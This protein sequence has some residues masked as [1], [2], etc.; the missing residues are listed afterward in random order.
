M[1]RGVGWNP[2]ASAD[3]Q[4]KLGRT[5]ALLDRV[6]APDR[7][8]TCVLIAGTKGKGSTAAFLARILAAAG[9]RAGLYTQPHLQSYRERVRVDGVAITPTELTGE[10][11]VLRDAVAALR[12]DHPE[13][14]EPTT[15]ELTTTLALHHFAAS[16]CA[17]AILEVG[18]GGRLDATNAVTPAVSLITPISRDHLAVLGPTLA[19]VA[20]E[21]AGILRRGRPAFSGPQLPELEAV[22]RS[23]ATGEGANVTFV[24]PLGSEVTV[25]LLGDHQRINAA[26]AAAAARALPG[27]AIGD[28]AI[29][30]GLA[31]AAW[32]GRFEVVP[33]SPTFVR[34]GAHNDA[35]AQA[36]ASTLQAYAAVR[37]IVL[38]VGIQADKEALVVLRP[39]CAIASRA[40]ATRSTSRRALPAEDVDRACRDLGTATLV[41]PSVARAIERAR[42]ESGAGTIVAVTGSLAV[43]GEAREALGLPIV[44]R[45]W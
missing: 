1:E 43:V 40:I 7:T 17:V 19:D 22:I 5:R 16:G 4:W 2:R 32:P 27:I 6:R 15:F 13:A 45:L 35:S 8:L 29:A 39:L 9:V 20:R 23:V 18:L 24:A 31:R 26:L 12:R 41:E 14:G 36:F 37:P 42:T 11:G 3:E 38:V 25:A 34:D 28:G 21:K 44:E 10:V 33:G 30:E